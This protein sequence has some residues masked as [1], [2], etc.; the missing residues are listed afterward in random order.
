MNWDNE[1]DP[2]FLVVKINTWFKN[3]NPHFDI[4]LLKV[5]HVHCVLN[6]ATTYITQ[7][8]HL[9][10]F[11]ACKFLQS[12]FNSIFINM[13]SRLFDLIDVHVIV[14]LSNYRWNGEL[15]WFLNL[16]VATNLVKIHWNGGKQMRLNF[17][18]QIVKYLVCQTLGITSS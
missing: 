2:L 9:I 18:F 6:L 15:F 10:M 1:I 7:E 8:P 4:N 17:L 12:Q 14:I 5:H 11:G 3:P 13:L 16:Q